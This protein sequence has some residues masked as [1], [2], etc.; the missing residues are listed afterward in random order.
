MTYTRVIPRDLFNEASLL[1][2]LA[3]IYINLENLNVA[4]TGGADLEHD[5]DAFD[6]QQNPD[7]GGLRCAN[8]RL[9][10]R[11]ATCHLE[12]PLNSRRT[13][14][15]YLTIDDDSDP[16]DVFADDGEFSPEMLDFLKGEK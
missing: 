4:I 5:G 6:V 13:W 10:V 9:I 12:R 16:I 8:V 14:P 7:S 3:R 1:K 15:L 2:C 11:G